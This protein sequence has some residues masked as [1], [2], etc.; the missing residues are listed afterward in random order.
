MG[1]LNQKRKLL[2]EDVSFKFT[3]TGICQRG[4]K[5][6]PNLNRSHLRKIL[7]LR[8]S[9]SGRWEKEQGCAQKI[10]VIGVPFVPRANTS[11][12]PAP[13]QRELGTF[14]FETKLG[15]LAP[16]TPASLLPAKLSCLACV[17]YES[18][19]PTPV[20]YGSPYQ[21]LTN[22]GGKFKTKPC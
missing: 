12:R 11:A 4:S 8:E 6:N 10:L 22:P 7:R 21:Y 19:I 15:L 9:W 2:F 17:G 3:N 13:L 14:L 16:S 18:T 1:A 5:N 20:A